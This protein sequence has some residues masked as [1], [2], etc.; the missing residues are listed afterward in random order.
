MQSYED[1]P[2]KARSLK[3]SLP[4]LKQEIEECLK[5]L[6][7]IISREEVRENFSSLIGDLRF[8]GKKRTEYIDTA[9]TWLSNHGTTP[10]AILTYAWMNR[11]SA[12]ADGCDDNPR[13]IKQ[14][15]D[16]NTIRYSFNEMRENG[17]LP[18]NIKREDLLRYSPILAELV[19]HYDGV[20]AIKTLA[21]LKEKFNPDFE[22]PPMKIDLGEGWIGEVLLKNDPRGMTIGND[23]GCC[24]TLGGVSSSCI[25]AGYEKP[26]YGF[27]LFIE[28]MSW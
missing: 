4:E 1:N 7:E 3:I 10:R 9:Q 27:L 26:E 5:E 25:E 22:I 18:D 20:I 15:A 24:M 28:M 16:L 8:I 23:T 19:R 12:L 11:E 17:S 6:K 2:K 14:W 21:K 13:A